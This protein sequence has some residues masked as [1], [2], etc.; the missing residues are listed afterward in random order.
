MI[1]RLFKQL[2]MGGN[3]ARGKRLGLEQDPRGGA[4]GSGHGG[5]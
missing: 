1:L 4:R 3:L 5:R 2:D